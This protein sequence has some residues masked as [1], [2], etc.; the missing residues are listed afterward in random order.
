MVMKTSSH[1]RLLS[2]DFDE[3]AVLGEQALE[4][5]EADQFGGRD[6][7]PVGQAEVHGV[8][9]RQDNPDQVESSGGGQEQLGDALARYRIGPC[10]LA[11]L[12]AFGKSLAD[13]RHGQHDLDHQPNQ[14]HQGDPKAQCRACTGVRPCSGL[15][16]YE[17]V[18][19]ETQIPKAQRPR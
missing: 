8:K 17:Q 16:R 5:G 15:P 18:V 3:D 19:D 7:I 11:L 13:G 9:S 6:A 14:R 4:I 2:S 10:R 12:E 1:R